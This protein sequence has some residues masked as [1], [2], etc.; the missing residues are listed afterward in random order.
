MPPTIMDCARAFAEIAA[1]AEAAEGPS[2]PAVREAIHGEDWLG[3]GPGALGALS[4]P[5]VTR[6][7]EG[8][9]G[10]D[11]TEMSE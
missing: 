9:V 7:P 8:W 4:P 2:V 3:P 5:T 10:P 1:P 11:E 6:V